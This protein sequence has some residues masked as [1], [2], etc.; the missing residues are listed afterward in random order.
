MQEIAKRI[1]SRALE[2]LAD[3]TV[4][5]VI[6][7]E[8]G[9]MEADWSPALFTTADEMAGFVYGEHSGANLSKYCVRFNRAEGK[10]LIVLKPCDTLSFNQL[11][12]EHRVNRENFYIIGAGC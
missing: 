7:W 4:A 3:G 6:G 10:T 1:K 2:L 5:R 8:Q 11:C 12:K 9:E